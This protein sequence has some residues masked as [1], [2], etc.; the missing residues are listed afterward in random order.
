[1]PVI[2][3]ENDHRY[4]STLPSLI[5]RHLQFIKANNPVLSLRVPMHFSNVGTLLRTKGNFHVLTKFINKI[6]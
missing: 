6:F 2:V 4:D 1:M 5:L 3:K